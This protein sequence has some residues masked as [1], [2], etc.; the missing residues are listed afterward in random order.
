MDT[1]TATEWI[2]LAKAVEYE[3]AS[4]G[5][6]LRDPYRSSLYALRDFAKSLR[7]R[8][9]QAAASAT[10]QRPAAVGD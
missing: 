5:A 3:A 9:E 8:Q 2:A 4:L 7:E 10:A 6:Y 1:P